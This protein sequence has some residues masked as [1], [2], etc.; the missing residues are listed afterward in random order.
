MRPIRLLSACLLL[1]ACGGAEPAP[2]TARATD[3]PSPEVRSSGQSDHDVCVSLFQR[4]RACTDVYLPALVDVRIRHD[5]PPGIAA[6]AA[7]PGGR[8]ALIAQA[9]AEWANDSTDPAI[10][11]TCN[12]LVASTPPDQLAGMREQATACIGAATCE[13]FVDC[14]LPVIEARFSK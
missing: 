10:D 2:T 1:A 14:F 13:A 12:Q 6:S 4:Q 9:N 8:D 3:Q 5:V 11:A 7:E